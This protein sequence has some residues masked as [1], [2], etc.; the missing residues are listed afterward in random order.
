MK[1]NMSEVFELIYATPLSS[2]EIGERSTIEYHMA[3]AEDAKWSLSKC[4]IDT[5]MKS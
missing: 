2:N 4:I 1:L 5:Q 3:S